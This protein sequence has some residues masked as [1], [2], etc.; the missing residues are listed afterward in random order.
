MRTETTTALQ[1]FWQ[2]LKA[3]GHR[4]LLLDYD[5]T[6]A[7]FRVERDEAVPYPGVRDLLDA[8]LADGKSRLVI[9]SGRSTEDLLP[10]LGLGNTP[11]IWGSHGWERLLP[12]GT[13]QDSELPKD[14]ARALE[15]AWQWV[16]DRGYRERCERKPVSVALHW[17][18]EPEERIEALDEETRAAWQPLAREGGLDLHA[19][20]GGLELR[21]PGRDKGTAV[22]EILSEV[23]SD[24]VAAY[25]GDDFT[26][27]DA[28]AA[29]SGRGLRVLVRGE[30]RQTA[31]DLRIE[32]PGELLEFLRL[33]RRV[34]NEG[35]S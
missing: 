25:L 18:G 27:E 24:A 11:E 8:I 20:D 13:R 26:D 34:C 32:P 10:L 29:L 21:C 6:L 33:W 3:A 15:S 30:P 12:D 19:F 35:G 2:Q 7:P 22:E 9:I 5:G 1:P 4:V 28:F 16:L 17:R 14:A 23:E 31:A